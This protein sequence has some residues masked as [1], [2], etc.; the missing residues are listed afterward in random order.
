MHSIANGYFWFG[1]IIFIIIMLGIDLYV[2]GGRK[3]HKVSIREALTWTIVWVSLALLFNL[4]IYWYLHEYHTA[5]FAKQKALEF[6]TGY[7]L[8]KSLSLDNIFV[9][10]LIFNYFAIPTHYQRRILLY[11]VFGAIIMRATF[12]LAGVWLINQFEWILFIFAAFLIFSG[13]R[14]LFFAEHKP[15]LANNPVLIFLQ[16]H[17]RVT[18]ELHQEK[19]TIIQNGVRYL[20]PLFLVL[21]L[22]E[23]SDVVFAVDSIPAIFGI[24]WDPFIVF[25]SNIFAILGLRALYFLLAHMAERFQLLEYGIAIVLIFIGVKM[26]I[27]PWYHIPI[28][29]SLCTIAVIIIASVLLSLIH[30]KTIN[31]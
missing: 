5:V 11:G 8:E 6:F 21:I 12:I 7:V 23:I 19:F 17:F 2:F 1:F 22:I 20:T 18:K 25:T 4:L 9:F 13:A 10:V 27:E 14:M 31:Q 29:I 26:V 16:K 15:D 3:A 28:I 24:T 30:N